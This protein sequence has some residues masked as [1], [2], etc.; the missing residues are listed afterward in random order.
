MAAA[1]YNNNN[2][3]NKIHISTMASIHT[4]GSSSSTIT[5]A[6]R[7]GCRRLQVSWF[8]PNMRKH[9]KTDTHCLQSFSIVVVLVVVSTLYLEAHTDEGMMAFAVIQTQDEVS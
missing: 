8:I 4:T 5:N 2:K 1:A 3:N 7:F 9:N 6:W